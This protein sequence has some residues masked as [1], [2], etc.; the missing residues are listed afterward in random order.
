MKTKERV[1]R[2]GEVFTPIEVVNELLDEVS[3]VADMVE[4]KTL[5]IACGT[6]H[7]AKQILIR[8]LD[9]IC[10]WAFLSERTLMENLLKGLMSVYGLELQEDNVVECR[11][12]LF[13][14]FIERLGGMPGMPNNDE[15]AQAAMYVLTRNIVQAD[16]LTMQKTNGAAIQFPQWSY[17]DG[18]YMHEEFLVECNVTKKGGQAE[19]EKTNKN[20]RGVRFTRVGSVQFKSVRDLANCWNE[21][22]GKGEHYAV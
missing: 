10:G 21:I 12:K 18:I 14:V 7:F 20:K 4:G 6:G 16:A 9:A 1:D 13:K 15:W 2:Y 19:A 3:A 22:N 8:K 17:I 5:D 11:D